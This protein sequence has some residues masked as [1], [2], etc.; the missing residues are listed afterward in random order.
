MGTIYNKNALREVHSEPLFQYFFSILNFNLWIH[1]DLD[2]WN[3]VTDIYCP[4]KR[5][6]PYIY[7][8]DAKQSIKKGLFVAVNNTTC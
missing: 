4:L 8:Q 5:L 7:T 3:T 2:I 6:T 1:N